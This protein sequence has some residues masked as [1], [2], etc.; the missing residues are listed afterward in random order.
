M[1]WLVRSSSFGRRYSGSKSE[2]EKLP[3]N[4]RQTASS[5]AGRVRSSR[6]MPILVAPTLRR[7]TPSATAERKMTPCM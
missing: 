3:P 2:I 6:L 4:A 5:V 7:F 1:Y